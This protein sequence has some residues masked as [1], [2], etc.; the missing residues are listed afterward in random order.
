M[1]TASAEFSGDDNVQFYIDGIQDETWYNTN[2]GD[3][4]Y[5][6]ITS[7]SYSDTT[8][9]I[10]GSKCNGEWVD[11]SESADDYIH[12]DGRIANIQ[13]L[14]KFVSTE[15]SIL[16]PK[17]ASNIAHMSIPFSICVCWLTESPHA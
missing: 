3:P 13:I 10:G 11:Q 4:N 14:N 8:L 12:F 2:D 7:P 15:V 5:D 9:T 17:S 6:D 16:L 1:D